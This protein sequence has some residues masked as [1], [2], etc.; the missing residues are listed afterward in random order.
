MFKSFLN[1]I[2]GFGRHVYEC[3]ELSLT[4]SKIEINDT[5][6][7]HTCSM[8]DGIGKSSAEII[9]K[10]ATAAAVPAAV[11]VGAAVGAVS[12]GIRAAENIKS[13]I[14]KTA[15]IT[16]VVAGGAAVVMG[17]VFLL[18]KVSLIALAA[19]GTSTVLYA[20]S[21]RRFTKRFEAKLGLAKYEF[22]KQMSGIVSAETDTA[23]PVAD[24][25][26]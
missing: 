17:G 18:A 23:T 3:V 6:S 1:S 26:A 15:V 22:D 5:V 16:A 14:A 12:S 7:D 10:V 21:S 4:A 11:V 19:F 2:A 13:P 20:A 25:A 8:Q 24:A 9:G